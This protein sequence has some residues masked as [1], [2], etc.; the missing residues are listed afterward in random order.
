MI[1]AEYTSAKRSAD[2]LIAF[3][4]SDFPDT[5]ARLFI[6]IAEQALEGIASNEWVCFEKA[7]VVNDLP[8]GGIQSFFSRGDA[9]SFRDLV[10]ANHGM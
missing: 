9:Q 2:F 6:M 3:Q 8:S 5:A 4:I 1:S 10:Y 7:L